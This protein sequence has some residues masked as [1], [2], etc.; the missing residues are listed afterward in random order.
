MLSCILELVIIYTHP[1][2]HRE[3]AHKYNVERKYKIFVFVKSRV[4]TCISEYLRVVLCSNKTSHGFKEHTLLWEELN[5]D[6]SRS[7]FMIDLCTVLASPY[8]NVPLRVTKTTLKSAWNQYHF[9]GISTLGNTDDNC[10]KRQR[11]IKQDLNNLI[12][13]L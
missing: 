1:Y 5:G 13:F 4:V 8:G 9:V 3:F 2:T 6:W 11:K 12:K 10:S 7:T